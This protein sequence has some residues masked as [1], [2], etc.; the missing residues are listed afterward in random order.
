M[1]NLTIACVT[2]ALL[3]SVAAHAAPGIEATAA[4]MSSESYSVPITLHGDSAAI[5]A[6]GAE[7]SYDPAVL[8]LA[9]SSAGPAA[10][11]AGKQ[12]AATSSAKGH[13][14]LGIFG[15]NANKISD[16][17]VANVTFRVKP[18]QE[19]AAKTVGYD[20]TASTPAGENLPLAQPQ[21]SLTLE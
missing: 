19:Q 4:K 1:R 15:F 14:T 21:G 17:V 20:F 2:L 13:L 8:E 9:G 18:G 10:T 7:L 11:T 12:V 16:G 6:L 3:H 5:A